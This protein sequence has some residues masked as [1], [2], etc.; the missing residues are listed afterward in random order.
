MPEATR[1]HCSVLYAG[2]PASHCPPEPAVARTARIHKSNLRRAR[3]PDS[4]STCGTTHY[5]LRKTMLRGVAGVVSATGGSRGRSRR[6]LSWSLSLR[7]S[8]RPTAK[9]RYYVNTTYLQ[10]WS[11]P[12]QVHARTSTGSTTLARGTSP[13]AEQFTRK[14]G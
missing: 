4:I 5:W 11:C 10:Q 8:L 12:D 1:P 13:N 9:T 3:C 2:H 14:T 6:P 7:A